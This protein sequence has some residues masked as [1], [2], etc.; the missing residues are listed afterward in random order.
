MKIQWALK[1]NGVTLIELLVALVIFG[2]IIGAIYQLFIAQTRAYTVQDQAV[3]VQ[4]TLRNAMEILVRDLRMAG[5]D[6]D[7]LASTVMIPIPIVTPVQASDI[8]VNYESY[9]STLAQYQR[10]TVSYWRDAATSTLFRQRTINAVAE[11]AEPLLENVDALTFTYGVDTNLDGNVD[12]WVSPT[13]VGV[14]KVIAVRIGLTARP[15]QINPDVAA[16]VSPR[17]LTTVVIFRN[18]IMK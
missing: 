15:S 11:A 4:Q 5:Y 8:T 12:N 14:S 17:T 3:E 6:D 7:N 10:H 9:D 13:G 18:I 2:V 16:R 1:R